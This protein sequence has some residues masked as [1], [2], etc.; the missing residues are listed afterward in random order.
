MQVMFVDDESRV[1]SGIGNVALPI[2]A[3]KPL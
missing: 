2:V 1:L 3:T